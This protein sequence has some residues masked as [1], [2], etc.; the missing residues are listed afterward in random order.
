MMRGSMKALHRRRYIAASL[1][2]CLAALAIKPFYPYL[3]FG[4]FY[5]TAIERIL[6]AQAQP[7]S[8]LDFLDTEAREHLGRLCG[9]ERVTPRSMSEYRNLTDP[10]ERPADE[11]EENANT[12]DE[13]DDAA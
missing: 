5:S 8:G 12:D 11:K 4:V 10:E 2:W 7:R 6:G 3:D 1:L 9:D 13:P